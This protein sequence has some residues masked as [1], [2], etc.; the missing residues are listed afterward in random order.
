MSSRMVITRVDTSSAAARTL[1][2]MGEALEEPP[3]EPGS[4]SGFIADA[5]YHAVWAGEEAYTAAAQATARA[6]TKR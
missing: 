4:F 5:M 3:G 6:A 1:E 2:A